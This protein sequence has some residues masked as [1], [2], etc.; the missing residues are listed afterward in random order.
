MKA[1]LTKFDLDLIHKCAVVSKTVY[2]HGVEGRSEFEYLANVFGI[3]PDSIEFIEDKKSSTEAF[4]LNF[5]PRAILGF[6][7]TESNIDIARDALFELL[8]WKG[9]GHF[10]RGFRDAVID[11][12]GIVFEAIQRAIASGTTE[13]VL[14]G[15]SLGGAMAQL[16]AYEI[17]NEKLPIEVSHVVTFGQ[18]RVG[19]KAAVE[20]FSDINT[21]LLR[22]VNEGDAVPRVPP[23]L[24]AH[25]WTH[26]GEVI[27]F[28][29][30][31]HRIQRR[32]EDQKDI[33]VLV[34]IVVSFIQAWR[35]GR[36]S[37]QVGVIKT[38]HSMALYLRNV[39]DL[40]KS[41][42]PDPDLIDPVSRVSGE[43]QLESRA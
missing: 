41:T 14:T 12:K 31:G 26:A 11:S 33:G 28:S 1:E 13:I 7:G 22:I 32:A 23:A 3:H 18:P 16:F 30:E 21:K 9:N 15:H 10:H 8:P 29:K 43:S 2:E 24:L 4:L 35:E 6:R 39:S 34:D 42:A 36:V 17:I 19:N 25:T 37:D 20:Q 40:K 27:Q 5:G 38:P